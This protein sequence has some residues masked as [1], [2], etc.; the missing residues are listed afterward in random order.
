MVS[1]LLSNYTSTKSWR[2]Y[3]F[4]S[5]CLCVCMCVFMCVCVCV[6]LCTKFQPTRCTDLNAVFAKQLL[7][8]YPRTLLKSVTLGQ[9]SRSHKSLLTSLLYNSALV[10]L[11]KLKFGMPHTYALCRFVCEFQ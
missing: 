4:T 10:Y 9:R 1:I 11:I 2:G 5:V 8:A 6:F 3:I 7:T